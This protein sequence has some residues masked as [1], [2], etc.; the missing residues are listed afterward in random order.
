MTAT[1]ANPPPV[2]PVN[3]PGGPLLYALADML[4]TNV[5]FVQKSYRSHES[6]LIS[7]GESRLKADV[8][9]FA[10]QVSPELVTAFIRI[11]M[12]LWAYAVITTTGKWLLLF[13]NAHAKL[14]VGAEKEFGT[15]NGL[16]TLRK[17]KP[18]IRSA[19]AFIDN[20]W[21]VADPHILTAEL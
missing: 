9:S 14:R 7:V 16:A 13:D 2:N 17:L 19:Y 10:D 6:R 3:T 8:T 18:A 5:Y 12:D 11:R 21:Q 15:G 1:A 20:K 4:G